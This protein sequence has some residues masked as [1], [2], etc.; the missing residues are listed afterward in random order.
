VSSYVSRPSSSHGPAESPIPF[1]GYLAT[2]TSLP[3]T[4]TRVKLSLFLQGS[5]SYD[6]QTTLDRIDHGDTDDDLSFEKAIIHGRLGNHHAA[7]SILVRSL[8]DSTSAEAYC[9]LGGDV[10]SVKVALAVGKQL[11][12]EPW[13]NLVASGGTGPPKS[14][15]S[16]FSSRSNITGE[17]KRKDLLRILME[18]YMAGGP[19]MSVETAHLLN[20]QAVNLDVI[21]VLQSVPPTWSLNVIS[22]FLSRSLRRTLHAQH[23]GQII[24]A[25]AAGQNLV[26]SDLAFETFREQ[27]ALI[28]EPAEDDE[29]EELINEKTAFGTGV[30]SISEKPHD[31]DELSPKTKPITVI[32]P[33]GIQ[34]PTDGATSLSVD[35]SRTLGS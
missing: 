6:L 16:G 9:S 3:S 7:L 25:L 35:S 1:L 32:M 27:G 14:K 15:G 20:A 29:P 28:E 8:H 31:N 12:I 5:T 11:R 33:N 34:R 22:T 17:G 19:E 26:A 21:D 2:Y 4:L 13:A 23:E 24:K 30:E 10:I 18:V